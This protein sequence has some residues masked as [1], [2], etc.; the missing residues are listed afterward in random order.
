MAPF[1]M[2]TIRKFYALR[3][4]GHTIGLERNNVFVFWFFD[5]RTK[6]AFQIDSYKRS[7]DR[8]IFGAWYRLANNNCCAQIHLA[9]M[10]D[11]KSNS[12]AIYDHFSIANK[13][14]W[15]KFKWFDRMEDNVPIGR[16]L[17]SFRTIRFDWLQ[18]FRE[19][20]REREMLASI[21]KSQ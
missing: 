20:K 6:F 8:G 16:R 7:Q 15:W 13:S 21:N 11:W 10:S 14:M 19:R 12:V 2:Q 4:Y 18:P 9:Q 3:Q 17:S 1:K 5:F